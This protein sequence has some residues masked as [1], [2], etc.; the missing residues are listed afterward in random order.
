M[1]KVRV[2]ELAKEFGLTSKEMEA[3][4]RELGF[5]IK[6]YMSTLEDYEVDA[7]RRKM[8]GG[9]EAAEATGGDKPRAKKVIRRR[10]QVFRIK[11][12]IKGGT[13]TEVAPS[14]AAAPGGET[15][16]TPP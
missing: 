10:H 13:E 9:G 16:E 8:R 3:R 12:I 2:H 6:S 4:V 7:I 1:G 11:K 14:E 15:P 5:E